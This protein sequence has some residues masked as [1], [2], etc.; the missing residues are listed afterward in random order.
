MFVEKTEKVQVEIEVFTLIIS[1]LF[2][3]HFSLIMD[4]CYLLFLHNG[5]Y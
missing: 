2:Y 1:L 4:L 5:G 3:W